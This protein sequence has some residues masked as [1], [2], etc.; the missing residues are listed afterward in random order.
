[1]FSFF[2]NPWTMAAGLAL[3]PVYVFYFLL[4]K[5]RIQRS[6]TDYLP[7]QESPP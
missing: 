3:V 4:E 5:Q 6:W 2:L 7:V 1:M